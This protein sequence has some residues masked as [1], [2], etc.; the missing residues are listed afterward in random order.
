LGLAAEPKSRRRRTKAV[1]HSSAAPHPHVR[2]PE[3]AQLRPAATA[4]AALP[5]ASPAY[6]SL[7]RRSPRIVDVRDLYPDGSAPDVW[8]LLLRAGAHSMEPTPSKT[9]SL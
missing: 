8:S 3:P 9:E 6:E 4:F 2:I 7:G 1:H 5:I